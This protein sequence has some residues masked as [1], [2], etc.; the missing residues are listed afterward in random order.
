MLLAES[1]RE[2]GVCE[3]GQFAF[4]VLLEKLVLLRGRNHRFNQ[5]VIGQD[6]FRDAPAEYIPASRGLPPSGWVLCLPARERFQL[7]ASNSFKP[8]QQ[9]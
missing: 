1:L 5:R 3:F 7:I 8:S 6:I 9:F 2:N 4:E